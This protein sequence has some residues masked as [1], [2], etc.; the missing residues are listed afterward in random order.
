VTCTL[1]VFSDKDGHNWCIVSFTVTVRELKF[2]RR[3]QSFWIE[4]DTV[5]VSTVLPRE[6]V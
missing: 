6:W 5:A 1:A 3:P 2:M 4:T